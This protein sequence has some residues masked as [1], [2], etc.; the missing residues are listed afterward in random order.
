MAHS[1]FVSH[2]RLWLL[3]APLLLGVLAPA[4]PDDAAFEIG[5]EEQQSVERALGEDGAARLSRVTNDRFQ[6]WFVDTGAMRATMSVNNAAGAIP[7]AGATSLAA[8]WIRHFWMNVYRA[9][10]R[11]G[12]G[13]AWLAGGLVFLGAMLNDGAVHRSIRAAAAGFANPVAFHLAAHGILALAGVGASALLLPISLSAE[14]CTA[15]LVGAGLLCWR[16]ASS[17]HVGR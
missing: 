4:I 10:Y 3:A 6:R 11:A 9:L 1:R 5:R 2:L 8:G 13:L 17:F 15:A 14:W 7:D 12:A 16:M